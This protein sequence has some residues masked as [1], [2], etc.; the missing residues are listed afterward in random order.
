MWPLDKKF[1][2][3]GLLCK[4]LQYTWVLDI[5]ANEAHFL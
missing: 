2:D 5:A 1:G 3:P 4:L